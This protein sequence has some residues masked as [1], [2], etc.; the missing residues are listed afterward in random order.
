MIGFK[1][2][3][4]SVSPSVL[5]LYKLTTQFCLSCLF[6]SFFITETISK[7]NLKVDRKHPALY[8]CLTK[9][10]FSL[11]HLATCNLSLYTFCRWDLTT[12]ERIHYVLI[13]WKN[14]WPISFLKSAY[15]S[16]NLGSCAFILLFSKRFVL[17]TLPVIERQNKM[18][19][20]KIQFIFI[21]DKIKGKV[22]CPIDSIPRT[23]DMHRVRK[24]KTWP[25]R[26]QCL[27]KPSVYNWP[28]LPA[29]LR[30]ENRSRRKENNIKEQ[31]QARTSTHLT[32]TDQD[33]KNHK[34]MHSKWKNQR[35]CN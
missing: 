5:Y 30:T 1:V 8:V 22:L 19:L 6:V 7:V 31:W 16:C 17:S 13:F 35:T 32:T 12:S 14:S 9:L 2:R 26:L 23:I 28:T 11:N 29:Q 34:A 18:D 15:L 27:Q 25:F 33:T 10:L 24:D 20:K 4:L 3:S 21:V